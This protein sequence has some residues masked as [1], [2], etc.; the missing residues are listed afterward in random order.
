MPAQDVA[1]AGSWRGGRC[2][3]TAY[4]QPDEKTVLAAVTPLKL[5]DADALRKGAGAAPT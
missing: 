1:I 4:T 3:Q 2:L 5:R